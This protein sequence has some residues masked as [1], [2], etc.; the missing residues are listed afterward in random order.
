MKFLLFILSFHFLSISS[1]A[2]QQGVN[3]MTFEE[4][5]A[6]FNEEPKKVFIDFWADWCGYCK[7][8]DKYVFT[9]LE[10]QDRLN[11]DYYAVKMNAETVDTIYFGRK[12]FVNLTTG[13]RMLGFH[14]LAM[15][16]GKNDR[17]QFSLPTIV[18]YDEQFRPLRKFHK[19]LHSKNMI[20]ALDLTGK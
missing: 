12:P 6:A 17:G 15:L 16:L 9:N 1:N 18:I 11:K 7:R 13:D 2:Q 20:K 5:E 10:V 3:W 8:M 4:M 19:Y 14:Q